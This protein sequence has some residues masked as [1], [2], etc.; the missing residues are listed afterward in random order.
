MNLERRDEVIPRYAESNIQFTPRD[1][2]LELSTA[3][4][5]A[6]TIID[7]VTRFNF[8][9]LQSK[10]NDIGDDLLEHLSTSGE[11][12]PVEGGK[13]F[14]TS[15]ELLRPKANIKKGP[16]VTAM[17]KIVELN[18]LFGFTFSVNNNHKPPSS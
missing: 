3:D 9:L 2:S 4:I 8:Y 6:S 16:K 14:F 1:A 13:G 10:S 18:Q 17:V 11:F 7:A 5:H 15:G 12:F